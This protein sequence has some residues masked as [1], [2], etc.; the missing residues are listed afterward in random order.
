MGSLKRQRIILEELDRF[1]P[2]ISAM[3][4]E[5]A[6]QRKKFG[7]SSSKPM[8]LPDVVQLTVEILGV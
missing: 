2:P 7:I 6:A 8:L 5:V 4:T 3:E 1:V